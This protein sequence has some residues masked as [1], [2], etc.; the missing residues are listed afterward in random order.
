MRAEG[1]TQV[2]TISTYREESS[3]YKLKRRGTISS[4]KSDSNASSQDF[5]VYQEEVPPNIRL[6]LD[7]KRLGVSFVNR[8]L[9]EVVYLSVKSLKVEYTNSPVA[10]SLD[11]SFGELQ[12]DNQLHNAHFPTVLEPTPLPKDSRLGALPTLQAS[13]IILNDN[14]EYPNKET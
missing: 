3:L 7:L 6:N 1:Q 9:V 11:L 2:L 14:G 12:M 10:Q 8:Q 5:E 4:I 13:V